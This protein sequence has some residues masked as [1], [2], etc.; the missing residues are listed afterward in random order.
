MRIKKKAQTIPFM[1]TLAF[2][3]MLLTLSIVLFFTA[4]YAAFS[5]FR[6]GTTNA[7]MIYVALVLLTGYA[8]FYNMDRMKDARLSPEATK[9]MRRR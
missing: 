7:M 3:M 2:R 1:E 8:V 9:R 4:I 6:A 5:S